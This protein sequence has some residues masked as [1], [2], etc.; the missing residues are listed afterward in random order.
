MERQ[1]ERRRNGEEAFL[2]IK[3]QRKVLYSMGRKNQQ[4]TNKALKERFFYDEKKKR[5]NLKEVQK[6]E[7]GEERKN[8]KKKTTKKGK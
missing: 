6:Q 2:N 7:E 5:E 8:E 3:I 4:H 1:I